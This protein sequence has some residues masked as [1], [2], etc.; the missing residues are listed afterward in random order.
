M[1]IFCAFYYRRNV[2]ELSDLSENEAKSSLSESDIEEREETGKTCLL[3]RQ[4][5]CVQTDESYFNTLI[6]T[7]K[8]AGT[9][10]AADVIAEIEAEKSQQTL[11]GVGFS[12]LS[13][14]DGETDPKFARRPNPSLSVCSGEPIRISC[15]IIGTLPI[16]KIFDNLLMGCI[17]NYC[18]E[19]NSV[20]VQ[21]Y[22]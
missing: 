21:E 7:M 22:I 14:E 1:I 15:S 2:D 3:T 4:D 11:V 8:E 10:T 13:T 12:T 18:I 19:D 20:L 17:F 6:R 16:G 5:S 9:V